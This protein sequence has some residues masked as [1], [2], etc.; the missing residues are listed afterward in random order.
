VYALPVLTGSY[1]LTVSPSGYLPVTY[2]GITIS[3]DLTTTVDI[4]LTAAIEL[5]L[6][7]FYAAG[8]ALP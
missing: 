2:G 5:Y 8:A 4:T 3:A 6:P 7:L 1:T